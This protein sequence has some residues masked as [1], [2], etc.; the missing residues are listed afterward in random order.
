MPGIALYNDPF[1]KININIITITAAFPESYD[2]ENV[3]CLI[4]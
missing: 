2:F 1:F 4:T 3:K